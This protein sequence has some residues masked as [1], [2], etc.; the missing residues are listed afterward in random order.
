[1]S[2]IYK[3]INEL[4]LKKKEIINLK[5]Y[6][7]GSQELREQL[8]LALVSCE[9]KEEENGILQIFFH[10]TLRDLDEHQGHDKKRL[11][12]KDSWKQR[13]P[14]KQFFITEQMIAIWES[15]DKFS[16]HSIKRILSGPV[17]IGKSYIAWFFAAN[18]NY[19]VLYI[20]DASD[21]DCDKINSQ[22][23]VCQRFFAL[24]KDILTSTDLDELITAVTEDDPDSVI[25]KRCFSQIFSGLLKQELPRKTF[26]IIDE[27][28]ALLNN[29]TLVP[30]RL[31]SLQS[32]TNL[33]FW[34]EAKNGTRVIYTAKII[35]KR[36]YTLEGVKSILKHKE[37]RCKQFYD[38]AKTH[39]N[40]LPITSK[41]ETR[42][43]LVDIFLPS[44][45]KPTARF[46]W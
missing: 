39:Y 25:I 2:D 1:M 34:D 10:N 27:H 30:K 5:S 44:S 19:L 20:A 41:D 9:S 31:K 8:Q 12:V 21:L 14:G 35:G 45:P 40:S 4:S 6:L 37:Y 22:M 38:A 36:S 11:R 15:L 32:L 29:E 18:H 16:K 28:E 17:G 23:K 3:K 33:N 43:A 46:D 26:F 24:N 42:L 7:V 13:L